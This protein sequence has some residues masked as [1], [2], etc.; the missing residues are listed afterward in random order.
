ML[1][2]LVPNLHWFK[3]HWFK[4]VLFNISTWFLLSIFRSNYICKHH[5]QLDAESRLHEIFKDPVTPKTSSRSSGSRSSSRRRS[6]S[7]SSS[8]SSGSRSSGRRRSGGC[9]SSSSSSSSCSSFSSVYSFLPKM[10]A[11][12]S[13]SACLD[14]DAL[15]R[16]CCLLE[17]DLCFLSQKYSYLP[18][19]DIPCFASLQSVACP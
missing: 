7:C 3:G 1:L 2:P 17:D 9:S 8:S 19:S 14:R 5:I 4:V 18:P 13:V 11:K 16:L 15:L 10:R 6:G 12:P